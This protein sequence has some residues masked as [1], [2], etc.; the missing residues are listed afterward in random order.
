MDLES[1]LGALEQQKFE[2]PNNGKSNIIRLIND[3]LETA[4]REILK[5]YESN[6]TEKENDPR[7]G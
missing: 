3:N 1:I 7:D 2:L 4:Q 5:A 6:K